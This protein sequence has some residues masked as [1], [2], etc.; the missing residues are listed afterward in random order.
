MLRTW[1]ARL[2][3]RAHIE[4]TVSPLR[5]ELPG[6]ADLSA[7]ATI[8]RACST[9]RALRQS[10]A[11]AH[12]DLTAAKAVGRESAG[13]VQRAQARATAAERDRDALQERLQ[14]AITA[15]ARYADEALR[16]QEQQKGLRWVADEQDRLI[17]LARQTAPAARERDRRLE[18]VARILA[19]PHTGLARNLAERLQR[20]LGEAVHSPPPRGLVECEAHSTPPEVRA[21]RL[22]RSFTAAAKEARQ[23]RALA[24]ERAQVRIADLT[25]DLHAVE[26]V[27]REAK[28]ALD[29][30]GNCET[31]QDAVVLTGKLLRDLQDRAAL[32]PALREAWRRYAACPCCDVADR[33]HLAEVAAV[34]EA[35]CAPEA[36]P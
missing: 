19:E 4:I 22:D 24:H 28:N 8:T 2:S 11:L 3:T 27:I 7:E 1:L 26:E 12:T 10:L 25:K 30:D 20:V 14:E 21:E 9:L 16:L 17:T 6:A 13:W 33:P 36:Q 18:E 31:L 5:D 15:G 29:G 35:L 32:A 34:L 23:M